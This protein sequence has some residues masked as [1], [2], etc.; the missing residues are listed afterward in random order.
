MIKDVRNNKNIMINIKTKLPGPNVA[1]ALKRIEKYIGLFDPS[2]QFVYGGKGKGVYC[3]DLD[4]NVFMDWASQIACQPLGY[5]HPRMLEVSK[6]Y[7]N[8]NPLKLAGHDYYSTEHMELIEEMAS[9]LPQELQS[10]FLINSGAE[11][12]ENAIKIAYRRKPS[13]KIGISVQGAFHGRTLGALSCT[14]SKI[15]QKKNYPEI[16]MRRITLNNVEELNRLLKYD[17]D[18][19]N[20]AYVIA[21][22]IQGEGGYRFADKQWLQDLRRITQA[23]NILLILDEVQSGMGRTGKWW[24]F[25]HSGIVPDIITSAKALQVAATIGKKEV[26]P[27]ESGSISSTWGGGDLIHMA[28]GLEIIKTIKEE[29]L[30]D[31]VKVR[32]EYLLKKIKELEYK[33]SIVTNA[34]GLG[35]LLAFDLPN[36]EI[37]NKLVDLNFEKGLLTLG[38]GPHSLRIIPPYVISE[39]EIDIG[40]DILEQNLKLLSEGK[41]K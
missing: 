29:N 10:V 40:I 8:K 35:L 11:A 38:C 21:E 17:V 12:V 39:Q 7:S 13:A 37:R 14:N 4:E 28:M 24:A 6:K 33:Y 19:E 34:R 27:T 15:V 2:H 22:A 9:I 25:Q 5:N 36:G 32:G 23:H 1:T 18:P 41:S 20:V 31:Q 16:P 30:L 3:E 26:F